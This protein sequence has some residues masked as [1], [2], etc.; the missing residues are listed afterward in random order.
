MAANGAT[1]TGAPP[2]K[3]TKKSSDGANTEE[4]SETQK[5]LEQID[6]CQNEID[7]LNEQAS[8]EIL[9]VEQKYN[10]LRKPHLEKRNEF[11]KSI[12]NFWVTAFIN[13][14]QISGILEEEEKECLHYL[15]KLEVEEFEDIK[16]GYKINF[17]FKTNPFFENEVLT[18]EFQLG[19][20]GDPSSESTPIRWKEGKKLPKKSKDTKSRKRTLEQKS[21]FKW[22]TDN[23]DPSYDDIAEVI[24]DDM[25]PNPLQYY[26]VPDIEVENGVEEADSDD[27]PDDEEEEGLDEEDEEDLEGEEGEGEDEDL[28]DEEGEEEGEGADE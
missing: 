20:S 23:G 24:K 5:A 16:S 11:I 6:A 14:P 17:H 2:A 3:K 19:T 1:T 26:L 27:E 25:W 12:P 21:F 9:K 10:K 15:T 28:D 22:F 8:E 7:F 13:H 4:D 18:K